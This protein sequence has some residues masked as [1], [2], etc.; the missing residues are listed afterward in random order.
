MDSVE[1]LER[2]ACRYAA[3]SA[4]T[5]WQVVLFDGAALGAEAV[6]VVLDFEEGDGVALA[7]ERLVEDEDGGFHPGI[8]VETARRER[9]DGDEG[10]FH[11]QFA[12]VFVGGLALEDDAFG[13]DDGGAAGG[14][15]VLGH[16]VHEQDFAALGLDGEALVRLDAAFGRHEGRVG[17]DDVG[18]VVPAF[19]AGQGVVLENMRVG[20]AVQIEV[21]ET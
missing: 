18:E 17:E 19:F 3:S 8:G 4:C 15:E 5:C 7:G 1:A 13:D 16:V 11:E 14:G 6:A 21:H 10:I 9:N 2:S 12:Q 20:E